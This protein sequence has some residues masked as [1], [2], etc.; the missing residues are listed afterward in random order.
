[1]RLFESHICHLLEAV[2]ALSEQVAGCWLR[3]NEAAFWVQLIN[4]QWLGTVLEPT[5]F[6]GGQY[7]VH[8]SQL[9]VAEGEVQSE[10]KIEISKEREDE[11]AAKEVRRDAV[12]LPMFESELEKN[13]PAR[14]AREGRLEV[15]P[16]CR[17]FACAR[18]RAA[19]APT[20]SNCALCSAFPTNRTVV[21][22][23]CVALRK[24]CGL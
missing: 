10:S 13:M 20:Q 9:V 1:M 23:N 12:T 24:R 6:H 3:A 17:V 18:Y 5:P 21:F 22:Q 7:D 15:A 8:G 4:Q 2:Q 14:L 11:R 19:D 16:C